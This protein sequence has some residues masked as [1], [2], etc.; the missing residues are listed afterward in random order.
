MNA[1]FKTPMFVSKKWR[2]SARGQ[3]CT[4]RLDC[5]NGDETTVVLCHI[6]KFGWGG[7]ASKPHDF[8][9][10][11]ACSACHDVMDSRDAS[12]P[13]GNDDILRALGETLSIHYAEGRSWK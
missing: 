8:L 2:E 7:M 6:R 12:S 13:I 3:N 10:V 11:Y 4:L 1:F 5:C 9:A